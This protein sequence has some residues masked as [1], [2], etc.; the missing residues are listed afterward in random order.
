ME[1]RVNQIVFIFSRDSS[2][3]YEI[4]VFFLV[5][6]VFI[7]IGTVMKRFTSSRVSKEFSDSIVRTKRLEISKL[8][9]NEKT[10]RLGEAATRK[11]PWKN[12]LQTR[13]NSTGLRCDVRAFLLMAI[14]S[15]QVISSHNTNLHSK[16]SRNDDLNNL[17][18]TAKWKCD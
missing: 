12:K 10:S 2:F 4:S 8:D 1:C 3:P 11:S 14:N 5:K 17:L 13:S 18:Q 9:E 16:S 15:F 6:V 7:A